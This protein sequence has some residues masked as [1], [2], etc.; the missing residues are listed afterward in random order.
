MILDDLSLIADYRKTNPDNLDRALAWIQDNDLK[1]LPLGRTAI[2]G[3][4]LFVNV[5]ETVCRAPDEAL[6]ECHDK[7]IDIQIVLDG[8][9]RFEVAH[10][11]LKI[12]KPYS[13]ERDIAF[14][15]GE[16]DIFGV[17]NPGQFA[18]YR[19]GEAHK[20]ALHFGTPLA[21]KKAVFKVRGV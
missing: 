12:E 21:I 17:L 16:A 19:V 7:Y 3:D 4:D 10:G 18:I 14:F 9:E 2:A 5:E 15:S 1:S 11:A 13:P 6:F 8:R 20:P